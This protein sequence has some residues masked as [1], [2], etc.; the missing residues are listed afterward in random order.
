MGDKK[1][2]N[3]KD[4]IKARPKSNNDQLGENANESFDQNY[5]NK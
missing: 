1:N 2:K 4:K 3:K 5:D